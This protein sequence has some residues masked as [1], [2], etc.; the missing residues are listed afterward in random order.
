[1]FCVLCLIQL[2]DKLIFQFSVDGYAGFKRAVREMRASCGPP[3]QE[4]PVNHPCVSV[5]LMVVCLW[6]M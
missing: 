5:N 6:S 3:P 2:I 1:M 4:T